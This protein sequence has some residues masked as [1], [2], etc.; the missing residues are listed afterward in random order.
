V[1]VWFWRHLPGPFP[2]RLVLALLAFAVVVLLLFT[3]V[4]PRLEPLLPFNSV[5]VEPS[6]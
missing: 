6:G 5:T 1:Y 3:E 4:F 2:V